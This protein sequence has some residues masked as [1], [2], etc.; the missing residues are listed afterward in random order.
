MKL[1]DKLAFIFKWTGIKWLVN[2]I[3]IDWL[4]YKT[5]GCEGRQKALNEFKINRK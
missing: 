3:M 1:G 4:G 5:C 2:K